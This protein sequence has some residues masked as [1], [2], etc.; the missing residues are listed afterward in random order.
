MIIIYFILYVDPQKFA[1]PSNIICHSEEIASH[2]PPLNVVLHDTSTVLH[3]MELYKNKPM[4][5][6]PKNS[7]Y[8]NKF[9]KNDA[10]EELTAEIKITA[11]EC[12][13]KMTSLLVIICF[14]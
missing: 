2:L 9:A 13:K 10:W 8:Y 4:L 7:K 12:R 1:A 6:V 3:F 5:W 14:Q 11:D